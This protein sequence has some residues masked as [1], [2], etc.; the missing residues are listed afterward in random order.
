MM[1]WLYLNSFI[2]LLG[3]ELN[4]SLDLSK[5]SIKIIQPKFNSFKGEAV[6]QEFKKTINN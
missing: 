1:I 5:R 2:L 3:F 6:A 4:A